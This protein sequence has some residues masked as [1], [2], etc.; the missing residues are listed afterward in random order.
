M[1]ICLSLLRVS[2]GRVSVVGHQPVEFVL[3]IGSP[4]P[5]CTTAREIVDPAL[6]L[7]HHVYV[8]SY[9]QVQV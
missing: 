9:T 8:S 5:D 1:D 2:P 7:L 6:K 3:D 4:S